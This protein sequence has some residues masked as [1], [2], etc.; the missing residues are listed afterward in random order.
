MRC[1]YTIGKPEFSSGDTNANMEPSAESAKWLTSPGTET[2]NSIREG[3]GRFA[4]NQATP[5]PITKAT[6]P[7]A[8]S[9]AGILRRGALIRAVPLESVPESA[10]RANERSLAD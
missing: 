1:T 4:S 2:A 7:A 3:I 5:A 6:A 8:Q 10:L 9:S